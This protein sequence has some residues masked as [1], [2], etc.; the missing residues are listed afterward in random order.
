MAGQQVIK[1]RPREIQYFLGIDYN[2]MEELCNINGLQSSSIER[3][4][5]ERQAVC[6]LLKI[7]PDI[8]LQLS[9]EEL[10]SISSTVSLEIWEKGFVVFGN[11]G[12]HVILKGSARPQSL[13]YK[14]MLDDSLD[15]ESTADPEM[16]PSQILL[17]VGSCFGTLEPIPNLDVSSSVLSVITESYCQMLKISVREYRRIK[18]EIILHDKIRKKELIQ[19]CPFYAQWPKLSTNKLVAIMEWRKY[20]AG[21]VLVK[22]GEISS[23]AGY[24]MSGECHILRSIEVI[25]KRPLGKTVNETKHV[26]M[27]KLEKNE[28]FGEISIIQQEPFTCTVVT[29]TDVELGVI[30]DSALLEL[31]EVNQMLLQQTAELTF[32]KLNQEEINQK[33][34]HQEKQREWLKFKVNAH[35]LFWVYIQV[36][37][38]SRI[39]YFPTYTV[40]RFSNCG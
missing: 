37:F 1:A 36:Y 21:Y 27:G 39:R 14:K 5:A 2:K 8:V 7:F 30:S 38:L 31:D 9:D 3:T 15:F 16:D 40:Y 6:R 12:L 28:S 19:S 10:K 18:E 11:Q 35:F 26:I 25:V 32:G 22:E 29:G 20:P 34:I 17:S 24:I 33:Y 23:F 13:P 4:Y